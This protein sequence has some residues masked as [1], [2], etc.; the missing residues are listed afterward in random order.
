MSIAEARGLADGAEATISGVLTTDLGALESGRGGFVQDATG[1]IAIYLDSEVTGDHVAGT[2]V[3]L[4]GTLDSRF[5]QRIVR[6]A[7]PAIASG[8][9]MPFRIG[10]TLRRA[11]R[12]A[13][14]AGRR[15][16]P[17][18]RRGRWT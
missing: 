5:S 12:P 1:G 14:E 7:E 10:R 17:R 3:T 9:M 2:T 18:R 8:S 13:R 11:I 6:V 4:R 16:P 15:E